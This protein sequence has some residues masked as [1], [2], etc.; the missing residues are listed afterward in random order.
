[1][2]KIIPTLLIAATAMLGLSACGTDADKVS[3]NLSVAAEQFEVQRR[4]VG[5]NGITDEVLFLVEGRCSIE[6]ETGALI[7]TC[8]HSDDDYRKH[9]V[10]LS[11]NVTYV[12]TQLEGLDV[13]EYHTRIV[14]K[15]ENILPN[16]DLETSNS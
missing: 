5:I 14:L 13:S 7:V 1:M 4:I 12:A 6:R 16:F 10:G 9:Y 11:D 15:P 2:K 3:E 8:K